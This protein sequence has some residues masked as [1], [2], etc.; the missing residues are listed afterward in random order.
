MIDNFSEKFHK[1]PTYVQDFLISDYCIGLENI[2]AKKYD[3]TT[4]RVTLLGEVVSLIYFK[5]LRLENLEDKLKEFFPFLKED[6]SKKMAVD[7]VGMRAWVIDDYLD[8]ELVEDYIRG[9]DGKLDHYREYLEI[10]GEMVKQEKF[11]LVGD[12]EEYERIEKIEPFTPRE[13]DPEREKEDSIDIFASSLESLLYSSDA[14]TLNEYNEILIGLLIEDDKFKDD[15]GKAIY[16]NS[17]EIT[18]SEF[19]LDDKRKSPTISNWIKDFIVSQGT[20]MFNNVNISDYLVRSENVKKLVH[21]D[22]MK[23]QRMLQLYRNVKYFPES[24]GDKNPEQWEIFP[25]EFRENAISKMKKI[26]LP[27]TPEELE[28]DKLS[29]MA[30]KYS[31]GSLQH[32]VLAEEI[33]KKRKIEDLKIAAKKLPEG[34]MERKAILEEVKKLSD[35]IKEQN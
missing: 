2:I 34:S 7:V 27:K 12:E 19:R 3:L 8:T 21:E 9:N 1:L 18:D 16:V 6:E 32:L 33:N 11:G 22:K 28:I 29:Q 15:L 14:E 23:I 26:G 5:E 20:N 17:E 24:M 25:V 31:P 13:F 30:E 4:D 10:S 35:K